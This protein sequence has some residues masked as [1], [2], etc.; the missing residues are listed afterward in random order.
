[1]IPNKLHEV[2]K[3]GSLARVTD[4]KITNQKS[5]GHQN[6]ISIQVM[7]I[8]AWKVLFS[9]AKKIVAKKFLTKQLESGKKGKKGGKFHHAF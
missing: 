2:H 7:I 3:E 6:F 8:R 4:Q 5:Y 1:M 9:Y